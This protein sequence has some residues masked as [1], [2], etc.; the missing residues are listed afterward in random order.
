MSQY[1]HQRQVE[2]SEALKLLSQVFAQETTFGDKK[3]HECR[4]NFMAQRHLEQKPEIETRTDLQ[5][6]APSE[7]KSEKKGN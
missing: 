7:A 6:G 5:N 4:L 2:K 3:Y 1:Y